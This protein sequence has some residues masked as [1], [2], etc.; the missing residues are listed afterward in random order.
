MLT[1]LHDLRLTLRQLR[2]SPGFL[3]TAVATLTLAIAANVVVAGVVNGLIFHSLPVPDPQAVVQVQNPGFSGISMSYPNYRDLRDRSTET[4]SSLAAARFTRL[5]LGVDGAATPV[6]GFVVSGNFFQM[7]GLKPQLGRL[8]TPADDVAGGSRTVLLSNTCWHLRFHADPDIVGKRILVGKVPFTVVGVTPAGF[9]GT[10]QFL[11][12]EAWFPFHDGQAID[13]YNQFEDRGSSNPW[14][15]GR[16]R[17]GITRAQADADL[18]R[19][20][21]QMAQQFPAADKGTAWHTAPVGLIGETLGT[22]VRAFL[23]GVG[24]MSLLVL[25]AA[26]A[27]LGMLFSSRTLDRSREL[28]IRLAIGSSRTRI[29]RQLATESLLIALVGGVAASLLATL[30]LQSLSRYRPP[31]DL[32]I[33]VLVDADA[34]VY[35]IATTLAIATGLLFALLPARSIWRTDPNRTMRSAGSTNSTSDR[36]VFRSALL[37][38]QIALCCLLVTGAVTAFRGLQRTFS[39]PLGFQP[40]GITLATVDVALAGRLGPDQVAVQQRL[41]TAA[42]AIPGVTAAGY[43]DNQPLSVN[44]N[45]DAIYAPGTTVFDQTHVIDDAAAYSV[46]PTYFATVDTPLL[47][48]RT[49][50]NADTADTPDVA[51]I[52]QTLAHKLFGNADPIGRS[53]PR[54]NAKPVQ[55]VG[56]VADGK[57][58]ALT[59]DPTGAV[60]RPMLQRP[61]STAVL[62]VRSNRPSA[63]MTVALRKAVAS[64]D[65]AI[66]VFS[67]TSWPDALSIVTFPARAATAALGTMG[68]LAAMLAL[69]GIFGVASYTVTGRMREL[70]IRVALGAQGRNVLRAALGRTLLLLAIGSALGLVLGL[71][72]TRLLANIVYHAT[73]ADPVVLLAVIATMAALGA[74]STLLPARRALQAEPASLLRD[75]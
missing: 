57:Y 73:A 60:F 39:M 56:V 49:F 74:I 14:V 16:L 72:A 34:R 18:R 11:Q 40:L 41:F 63:E 7:L 13:G 3:L 64:V 52:N 22:P 12:G 32:P 36:S 54:F 35:L 43:S 27:N 55:V 65:P 75:Q 8:F 47:A 48:G 26:C 20:S 38:V 15:F 30:I 5:S 33:Q 61:D 28:G 21:Q 44:T 69:T 25:L 19:I 10:E 66:P 46:S 6:W 51:I 2:R 59:E 9:H 1:L 17:P 37:V 24:I 4:F 53:F 67:V 50:T 62:L 42:A 58:T 70:G 31:A 68:I 23:A 45:T 29:L 71:A